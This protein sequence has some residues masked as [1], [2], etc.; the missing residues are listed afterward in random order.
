MLYA[1]LEL[2]H[3][4][5]LLNLPQPKETHHLSLCCCQSP[6]NLQ[7]NFTWSVC[8]LVCAAYLVHIPGMLYCHA[9][10]TSL[11]WRGLLRRFETVSETPPSWD[12][13]FRSPVSASGSKTGLLLRV[14]QT[15]LVVS[16]FKTQ[17]LM[18]V[19]ET[20]RLEKLRQRRT[21]LDAL[22]TKGRRSLQLSVIAVTWHSWLTVLT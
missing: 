4:Q 14:F 7:L 17:I 16:V 21:D 6:C 9:N 2:L 13:K 18:G 19:F 10:Y 3:K 8:I 5:A 12:E 15:E 20:R 1:F 11:F 22:H